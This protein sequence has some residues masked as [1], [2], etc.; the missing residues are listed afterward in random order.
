MAKIQTDRLNLLRAQYKSAKMFLSTVN[1]MK[2]PHPD[3]K[4][5][6][7]SNLNRIRHQLQKE[8]KRLSWIVW[9]KTGRPATEWMVVEVAYPNVPVMA[10][11]LPMCRNYVTLMKGY[12]KYML[13]YVS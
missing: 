9:P 6:A 12:G 2:K 3:F 10:G 13:R 8:I 4:S 7:M 5:N 1:R 11:T